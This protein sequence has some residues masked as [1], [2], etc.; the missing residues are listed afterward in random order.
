MVFSIQKKY[1]NA[2]LS[3]SLKDDDEEG[4]DSI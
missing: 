2:L 1:N 4:N 3:A